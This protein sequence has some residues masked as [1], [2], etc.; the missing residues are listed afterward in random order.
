MSVLD[1]PVWNALSTK[2]ASFACG[3]DRARRFAPDIGPLAGARDET[4]ES[5]A[6]LAALIPSDG[7]LLLLQADPIVLP[8][9]AIAVTT[10]S[11]VQMVAD[12]L[13]LPARSDHHIERLTDADAPAMLALAT[14]TKPG[15]FAARTPMLGEFW[16]VK[17]RG[18]L[19]AMAGERMRH[20]GFTEVSG[21]CTHPD[22]RGRG[23]ARALSALVAERIALR[24][25]TPYLHAYATN[26]A[27]IQLYESL[28]FR[29]R[30]MMNVAAIVRA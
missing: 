30:S 27:A 16:G 18:V 3:G 20:D 9:G 23:L 29:L 26:T 15:P 17:D 4:P 11:G 6:E 28:G 5:L 1:R 12:K 2:L 14:L 13:G 24:G 7:T 19:V 21:V 8:P 22:A 10:A 25:E